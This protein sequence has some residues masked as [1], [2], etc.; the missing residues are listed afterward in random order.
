VMS[1]DPQKRRWLLVQ[2]HRIGV[3]QVVNAA[4]MVYPSDVDIDGA[5]KPIDVLRAFAEAFGCP[6][7]IGDIKSLFLETKLYPPGKPVTVDWTGAPPD[8]FVSITH[9]TDS[10]GQFRIGA[11]YCIDLH[12]YRAAL[13]S[14]GIDVPDPQLAGGRTISQTSTTYQPAKG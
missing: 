14:H 12:R 9:T 1:R 13:R 8:H 7:G 2:T 3:D 6:I 10:V 11:A 4:W 5:Q